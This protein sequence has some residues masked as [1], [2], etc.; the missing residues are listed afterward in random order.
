MLWPLPIRALTIQAPS[1]FDTTC[2]PIME[3]PIGVNGSMKQSQ[4]GSCRVAHYREKAP[5]SVRR[6]FTGFIRAALIA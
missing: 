3:L 4:R 2:I 6:L 1:A 5:H